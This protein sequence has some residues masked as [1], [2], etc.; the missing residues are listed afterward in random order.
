MTVALYG[1]ELESALAL[2][3]GRSGPAD[4]GRLRIE[5]GEEDLLLDSQG[6]LVA[7]CEEPQGFAVF[8]VPE[9]LLVWC[10]AAGVYRVYARAG[11]IRTAPAGTPDAWE[12]RLYSAVL[13]LL[14]AERGDL[15]LHAATVFDGPRAVAFCGASGRG[16]STLSAALGLSG[17]VVAAEDGTIVSGV[18]ERPLVWPGPMGVRV[19]AATWERLGGHADRE[20]SSDKA[21]RRCATDRAPLTGPRALAGVVVLR[22]RGVPQLELR[23]LDPAAGLRALMP[24]AIYAGP[25]SLAGTMQ[26]VARVVDRVAIFEARLPD[27]LMR[28]GDAAAE[29]LHAVSFDV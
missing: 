1:Y 4:R 17:R 24:N 25:E 14:L 29:I 6:D 22:E 2:D 8:R 19:T 15:A 9:G 28:L 7:W 18:D 5:L 21:N 16:K 3:H 23:R 10:Q 13:P 20:A 27:D 12:H 26:L 11:V